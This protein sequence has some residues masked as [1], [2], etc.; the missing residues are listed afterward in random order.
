MGGKII[1]HATAARDADGRIE[2]FVRGGDSGLWR[3]TQ[4]SPGGP[5]AGWVSMG[6]LLHDTPTPLLDGTNLLQ[7][8]VSGGDDSVWH[9]GQ[10]SPGVWF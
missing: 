7:V 6:G 10:S 4:S 2:A 3:N 1:D 9:I 5:W 8:F